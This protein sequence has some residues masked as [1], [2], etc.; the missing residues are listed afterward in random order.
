MVQAAADETVAN[1]FNDRARM[2]LAAGTIAVMA[3]AAGNVHAQSNSV[4]TP[5]N[6]AAVGAVVGGAA[7]TLL[8]KNGVGQLIGG[9]LG[10]LAGG[11]GGNWACSP[12]ARP[13]QDS[14]YGRPTSYGNTQYPM[15]EQRGSVG[16][17]IPKMALSINEQ[18]RLDSMSRSALDAKVAWKK[19]LF[20]IE[21]AQNSRSRFSLNTAM[22]SESLARQD[23][24]VKRD[25]FA[26]TVTRMNT[27]SESYQPRAVGRY[28]EIAA[29]ML[30]LDTRSNVTYSTLQE[31]DDLNMSQSP[32]YFA[33]AKRATSMRRN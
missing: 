27:G 11:A 33:E 6:C 15:A 25:A 10:A 13:P 17:S 23:F 9:A 30:E 29:S 14:S 5:S 24:E 20:D 7:G 19:S 28:M 22:E 18:E 2:F 32:A 16:R 1:K 3:M 12:P 8:S 4:L 21:N 26:N 31:K